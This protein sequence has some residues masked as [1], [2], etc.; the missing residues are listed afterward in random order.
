MNPLQS[1]YITQN[2]VLKNETGKVLVLEHVTG[3]WLLPGGKI[4]E[5]E[6]W[7]DA[8][9]REVY[10]ET[11]TKEFSIEKIVDVDSWIENKQGRYVVTF[12]GLIK[13]D[14]GVVLGE[15]HKGYAWISVEELDKYE[16]WTDKIKERILKALS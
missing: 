14:V 15:E 1:F 12:S 4:N 13:N 8:L 6:L 7:S 9:K 5:G 16:F 10:E 11:G 3:K 2:I